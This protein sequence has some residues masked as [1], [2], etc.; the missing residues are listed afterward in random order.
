METKMVENKK[1]I[2]DEQY[3]NQRYVYRFFK[4]ALDVVASGIGLIIL[5]PVFL[6]VSLAIKAEDPKGPIFYSQVRLG[7]GQRPFKMYKFRSMVVDADKKLEKLL[8]ENEVKGAMFKMKEDPRITRVGKFIRKHSLDEL[9]Q[10]WNVLAGDMTLVGPRPP[11]EREVADYSEYDKQRLIVKPGCTGLW[12]V[13]GRNNVGFKEMVELDLKY[14]RKSDF[15]FDSYIIL[16]T[17][18]IIVIPNDAY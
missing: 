7:K 17:F 3:Q 16:K 5:S 2:I 12:Q 4:R 6:I 13:S 14:I 15:W 1:I 9:P 18:G 10:L 8:K 11:L